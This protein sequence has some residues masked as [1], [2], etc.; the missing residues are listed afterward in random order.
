MKKIRYKNVHRIKCDQIKEK[1]DGREDGQGKSNRKQKLQEGEKGENTNDPCKTLYKIMA[2][3]EH[4]P[5]G[6]FSQ[7]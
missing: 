2:F 4:I 1:E 3:K 6:V 5:L 7:H